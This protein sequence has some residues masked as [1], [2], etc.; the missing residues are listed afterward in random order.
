[1]I[2]KKK[3]YALLLADTIVILNTGPEIITQAPKKFSEISYFI[4]GE[5]K[6]GDIKVKSEKNGCR[7][8]K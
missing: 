1:M 6:D 5:S 7:W 4:E 2:Q 8:K 3:T